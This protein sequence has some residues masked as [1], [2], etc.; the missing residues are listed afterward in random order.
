MDTPQVLENMNNFTWAVDL[1]RKS[2][3]LLTRQ[4]NT[5]EARLT[6]LQVRLHIAEVSQ[7]RLVLL[8]RV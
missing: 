5:D 6:R 8:C 1:W 4:A 2:L 3:V 7:A